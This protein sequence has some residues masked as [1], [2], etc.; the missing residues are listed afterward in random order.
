MVTVMDVDGSNIQSNQ[1]AYQIQPTVQLG[2]TGRPKRIRTHFTGEQLSELERLFRINRYLT[3]T[4]RVDTAKKLGLKERQ[5]KIWFQNRRMKYKRE[6]LNGSN[7]RSISPSQSLSSGISSPST[8]RSRSP[9]SEGSIA[10]L[11]DQQIR[12]NFIQLQSFNVAHE[13]ANEAQE[14]NFIEDDLFP[15]LLGVNDN[16]TQDLMNG[17]FDNWTLFLEDNLVE[18]DLAGL[19]IN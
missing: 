14:Y 6:N 15:E 8:Q 19:S 5:V 2:R 1:V 11:S 12:E 9:Q 4:A 7:N 13:P 17:D 3:R 10:Q 16:N 18:S